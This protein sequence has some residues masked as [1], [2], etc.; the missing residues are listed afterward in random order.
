MPT[1]VYARKPRV[2]RIVFHC[3]VCGKE[4]ALTR[5]EVRRRIK[6]SGPIRF[7][8][9]TCNGLG[10]RKPTSRTHVACGHCRTVFEKRTDHLTPVD[11]CSVACFAAARRT[12]NARWRD[13]D[14]IREYNRVYRDTNRE[15]LRAV[16]RAYRRRRPDVARAQ[17][18]ARRA[19]AKA[20]DFTEA[21]WLAVLDRFGHRCVCCGRSAA[22]VKL[23]A[24]HVIPVALGGPHRA[25]NIQPLCRW[26]NAAKGARHIDYRL[27]QEASST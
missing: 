20:G 7:C 16:Q 3:E 11:Y 22:E 17:L 6:Y 21:D 13:P 5:G 26:C 10:T 19:S 9:N 12:A 24:D 27:H 1:G 8:S 25:D 23:E 14:Q 4:I 2:E 18:R 15:H